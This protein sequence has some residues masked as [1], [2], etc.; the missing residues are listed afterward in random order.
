MAAHA[1]LIEIDTALTGT[2]LRA[3]HDPSPRSNNDVVNN[4]QTVGQA[5]A[6]AATPG[7]LLDLKTSG[8]ATSKLVAELIS[9]HPS[10]RVF[11]STPNRQML[12]TLAVTNPGALRLLSISSAGKLASL[13]RQPIDPAIQGVA[14]A[15][16][17]L[18]RSTSTTSSDAIS[19]SKPG[20]STQF[21]ALRAHVRSD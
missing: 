8:A 20:R 18:D 9:T 12:D 11:A 4:S 19:G 7:I 21:I 1:R 2:T 6:A 10:T 16:R 13:L 15:Q 5:W 14:I 3:R 17:L